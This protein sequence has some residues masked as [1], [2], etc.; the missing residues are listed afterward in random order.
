MHTYYVA[1]EI[2]LRK[3]VS[4]QGK[5]MVDIEKQVHKQKLPH[6]ILAMQIW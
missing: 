6:Y 2:L 3:M 1:V 4:S 5:D